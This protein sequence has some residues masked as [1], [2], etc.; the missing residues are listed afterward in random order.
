M[1]AINAVVAELQKTI[2][3]V[4]TDGIE[5]EYSPALISAVTRWAILLEQAIPWEIPETTSSGTMHFAD[6]RKF[7]GALLAI[8]NTH[9]LAHRIASQGVI[10]NWPIGSIVHMRSTAE[11]DSLIATISGLS[12]TVCTEVLSWYVF[13]PR[14]MAI[15]PSV[16]PFIEVRPRH[17]DCAVDHRRIEQHRAQFAEDTE[18]ESKI[19]KHGSGDQ[20]A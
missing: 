9:E 18:S 20:E 1:E 5:Y 16:Q 15:T 14:V 17:P 10:Q 3:F 4:S 2:K 19:E 6:V 13:D 8:V 7:W 12:T 11:W